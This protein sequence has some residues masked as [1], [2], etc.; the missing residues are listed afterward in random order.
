MNIKT[1]IQNVIQTWRDAQQMRRT[2]ELTDRFSVREINSTMFLCV[3]G[4]AFEQVN[5][6]KSAANICDK[7]SEARQAAIKYN[8][9]KT[10]R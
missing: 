6:N 8:D 1:K 10:N 9:Y 7:L 5:D 2:M 3:D 4:V